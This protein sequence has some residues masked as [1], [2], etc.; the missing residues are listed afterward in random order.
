[1]A[2]G[3]LDLNIVVKNQQALGKVNSQLSQ[4]QAS[5]VKL[6]TLLKGA[7]GALAAIGATKLIGSIVST[8]QD[9][10]TWVML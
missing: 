1:M 2:Q 8:R 4:L 5:S 6:S 3:N 9:L 7:A 10:R